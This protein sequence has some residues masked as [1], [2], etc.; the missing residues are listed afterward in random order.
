MRNSYYSRSKLDK[1]ADVQRSLSLNVLT[2]ISINPNPFIAQ[3]NSPI[4]VAIIL[5]IDYIYNHKNAGLCS[6]EDDYL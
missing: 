1:K 2:Y 6:L 3:I 5:I 4:A